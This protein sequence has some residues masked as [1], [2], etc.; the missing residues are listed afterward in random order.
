MDN[1]P[2]VLV[3]IEARF[4][5]EFHW[6][7]QEGQSTRFSW[8]MDDGRAGARG[9]IGLEAIQ[10]RGFVVVCSGRTG[11]IPTMATAR[12]RTRYQSRNFA[13]SMI[14]CEVDGKSMSILAVRGPRLHRRGGGT[15][16][17]QGRGKKKH[18]PGFS[19]YLGRPSHLPHPPHSPSCPCRSVYNSH[20][21][22]SSPTFTNAG[23]V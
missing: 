15:S 23:L 7:F 22:L 14:R 19:I 1:S 10:S 18:R 5:W 21:P 3:L 2:S 6:G 4:P 12:R 16:D 11:A 20:T 8:W 9:Q 13:A 17:Q